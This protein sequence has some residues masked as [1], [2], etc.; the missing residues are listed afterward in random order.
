MN[1]IQ[2]DEF[3]RHIN[4]ESCYTDDDALLLEILEASEDQVQKEININFDCAFK[5]EGKLP[6]SIAMQVKILAAT[7]YGNRDGISL[8]NIGNAPGNTPLTYGYLSG[9]NYNHSDIACFSFKKPY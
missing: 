4:M 7:W 8:G 3:K 6:P 5:L 2:L 1:Y 9:L